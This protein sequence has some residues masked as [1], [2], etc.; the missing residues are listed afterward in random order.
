M[1]RYRL[2][3]ALL[4][5]GWARNVA[6]TV[7]QEGMIAA[8]DAAAGDDSGEWV[9]GCVVPGM[10]NAHGH[11]FQ[12]A[13]AG[14]AEG[15]SGLRDS[16]WTWRR[17]MYALANELDARQ[18]RV[19]ATQLY[20]EMLKAGYTSIAEFH[21]LHC[22]PQG[23]LYEGVNPLWEAIDAAALDTGIG[24]TL[25]PTLYRSADF[26]ARPLRR[27]QRRFAL[28]LAD[29]LHVLAGRLDGERT[30]DRT[31]HYTGVAF[32][33]LRAVPME[34]LH[35]AVLA[36]DEFPTPLVLH[37]HVAEQLRE[38]NAC[39]RYTGRRPIELLLDKGLLGPRWCLVHA[40]HA[41]D[42]EIAG[43]A[44]SG[45]VVCV[46]PSTEG[47]LGD[48]YFDAT[49]LLDAGGR[50][51]IGS[52]SH[53]TV[54]PAEELRW[55]EYQQRLRRRRRAV[56]ATPQETQV[57]A[58]LWRAAALGGAQ[59]LGQPVG[60]LGPGRRADWIV[61]D[62][63]DPSLAGASGDGVLDRLVFAGARAAIRDV[64]VGG[65][66]VVRARRHALDEASAR[67]FADLQILRHAPARPR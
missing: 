24:L 9:A 53:V 66:W 47:N 25:L 46:C 50:L 56:L 64:M 27:E 33:S 16:F 59:A 11:A 36:L 41:T 30:V 38:V 51:C 4:A 15:R 23:G 44:A 49:R 52:D 26:G 40:T 3:H 60:T 39:R 45:A 34:I 10:P 55:L 22:D 19:I 7:T 20:I 57:G 43:I 6:V 37:I 48:G 31:V 65:R 17:A 35:E 21:Y 54:C 63:R 1:A 5:D 32:H 8:I 14:A 29:F 2:E 18:L 61:L 58:R 67:A 13:L 62:D 42:A 12:R 28:T